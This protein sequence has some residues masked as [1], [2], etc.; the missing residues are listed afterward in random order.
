MQMPINRAVRVAGLADRLACVETRR[1][2]QL[3]I[4]QIYAALAL[5]GR[6][7]SEEHIERVELLVE[8][9]EALLRERGATIDTDA[10]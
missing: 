10:I 4:T 5:A 9:A 8:R 1:K 7:S 6:N 2:L 3:V